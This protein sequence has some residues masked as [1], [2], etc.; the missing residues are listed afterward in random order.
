MNI[1]VKPTEISVSVDVTTPA[2][3]TQNITIDFP[4]IGGLLIELCEKYEIN[5]DKDSPLF[6]KMLEELDD[7]IRANI[8]IGGYIDVEI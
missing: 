7:C 2:D 5:I 6:N 3:I 8:E 1:I 4:S